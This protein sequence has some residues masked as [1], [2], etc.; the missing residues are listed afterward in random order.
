MAEDQKHF[1]LDWIKSDLLETLS[2][3]QAALEDFVEGEQ[4]ETR[5]RVCLTSLHQVH[6]TLVMLEL[7]GVTMLA[8][9]LERLAQG[10][11]NKKVAE[12]D[13]ATQVLM[14]G[15]LEL[16][17]YLEELQSGLPDSERPM[18]PLVNEARALLGDSLLDTPPP[19]MLEVTPTEDSVA[20]FEAIEGIEKARR[21]RAAYQQVL[22]SILKGEDRAKAVVTLQKIAHG[23]ERI[24]ARTPHAAQW[25]AF[26]EF[27]QAL[28]NYSGPLELG[29]VKLL[30]RVDAEI[31]DLAA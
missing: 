10:M 12:V 5:M 22:L 26:G 9:H 27:V 4:D 16:P 25:Q 24:C 21:I 17:G 30:R 14:Q 18:I 19:S 6:G 1:A 23:L 20:R 3:A 11:L 29:A 13:T 8:D 15:I 31:R 28:S 2:S 7:A